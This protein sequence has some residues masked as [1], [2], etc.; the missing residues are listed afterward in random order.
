V[1]VGI[2]VG[3]ASRRMGGAPK[4]LLEIDGEPLVARA[5]RVARSAGFEV[6][7]VG[8]ADAY[9]AVSGGCEAVAD[10]PAGIGPLGGLSALLARAGDGRAI[11]IGCDMP[12]VREAPLVALA[13]STSG[14]PI[15]AARRAPDAPWEPLF[16]RYDAKR[17]RPVLDAAIEAG[18]RSFQRFFARVEVAELVLDEGSR[19]VL[20]D[21]DT[22]DDVRRVRP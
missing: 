5:I 12:H 19:D 2:F 6:V 3:G 7:L 13:S 14:A 15:V 11:A 21:W 4:G 9:A 10:A 17:V 18:E 20:D 22:P 8:R 1:L 16:A